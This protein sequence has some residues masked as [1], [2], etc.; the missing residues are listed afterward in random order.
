[1]F[2]LKHQRDWLVPQ[3]CL[4]GPLKQMGHIVLVSSQRWLTNYF[5]S[6]DK[7]QQVWRDAQ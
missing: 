2:L 6:I 1:M 4:Q 7:W 5:L 3:N